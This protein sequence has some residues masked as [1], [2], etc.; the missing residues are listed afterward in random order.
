MPS[1]FDLFGDPVPEN[2]GR[3][4]RPQHVATLENRNKVTLLLALGWNNDR[5]ALALGI[6]QPTLR[7]NYF[8]VLKF[9]EEQR[10]RMTA[11]LATKLWEQVQAGNVTAMREWQAFVERNDLMK[12]GHATRPEKPAAE[13]KLGKKEAAMAAAK[14]PD[15]TDALGG[16]LAQRQGGDR[17]N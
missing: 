11:A 9:R 14:Q 2:H 8:Q 4:G 15:T 3:R 17:P 1:N 13:P 5:I 7:R 16:L 6:T 10:D 12:Y